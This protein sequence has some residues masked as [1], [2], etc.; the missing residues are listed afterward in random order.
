MTGPW[1][2]WQISKAVEKGRPLSPRLARKIRRDAESRR[3]YEASLAMAKRL[4][5]DAEKLVRVE[6]IR[7][8]EMGPLVPLEAGTIPSS[9]RAWSRRPVLAMGTAAAV[10][11]LALGAT[12]WWQPSSLPVPHAEPPRAVQK[13]DVAELAQLIRQIKANV[14]RVAERKAPDWQQVMARSGEALWTPIA[15]E[16]ENM[17]ADT[18]EILRAFSSMIPSSDEK[19]PSRTEADAPSPSSSGRGDRAPRETA[20]LASSWTPAD[21]PL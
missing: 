16:A 7:L 15:R 18:R 3:F 6:Q 17:A 12:L 8:G 4:R 1:T 10:I 2:K 11:C 21:V 19:E 14:D 13:A 20:S 5:R 9:R